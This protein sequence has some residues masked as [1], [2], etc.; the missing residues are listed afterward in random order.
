V[1]ELKKAK[2]QVRVGIVTFASD[3]CILGD[4][5]T[6]PVVIAGD[7]LNNEEALVSQGR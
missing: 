1:E 6:A 4:G 7:K 3:V 2:P 5:T